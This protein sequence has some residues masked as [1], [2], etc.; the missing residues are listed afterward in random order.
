MLNVI[1]SLITLGLLDCF[2]PTIIAIVLILIPTVEKKWYPVIFIGATYVIYLVLGVLVY[3]GLYTYIS[4]IFSNIFVHYQNVVA[5]ILLVCGTVLSLY[6]FYLI[7]K[8]ISRMLTKTAHPGGQPRHSLVR[9][10]TPKALIILAVSATI[11]DFPTAIP[12]FGFIAILLQQQ[13]AMP[14]A[15]ILIGAYCFIYS[16]PMLLVYYTSIKVPKAAFR[17]FEQK[18][19]KWMTRLSIYATP[20]I[21]LGLGAVV[22]F[23][24]LQLL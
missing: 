12:Y 22:I 17:T 19:K 24:A 9:M 8:I 20:F 15:L 14:A 4:L 2:N 3:F 1:I 6:G 5:I 11:I 7:G 10:T 21:F 18:S 13:V 23:E 16:I